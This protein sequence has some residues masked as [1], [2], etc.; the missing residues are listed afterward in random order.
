MVILSFN[1]FSLKDLMDYWIRLV[2]YQ[3]DVM[4]FREEKR[5]V[6]EEVVVVQEGEA[7][8]KTILN[9]SKIKR[10]LI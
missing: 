5:M 10:P 4:A 9:N 2:L 7:V 1:I 6:Q 3:N 8:R